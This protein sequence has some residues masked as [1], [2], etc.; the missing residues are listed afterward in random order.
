MGDSADD[1]ESLLGVVLLEL[2]PDWWLPQGYSL[3]PSGPPQVPIYVIDPLGQERRIYATAEFRPSQQRVSSIAEVMRRE[4][5]P[6][7]MGFSPET[8]HQLGMDRPD[9]L[10]ATNRT[11]MMPF[12]SAV[13]L[14]DLANYGIAATIVASTQ[15]MA[16]LGWI[17]E[18]S[19]GQ[20]RRDANLAML[21]AG[22]EA[23][24]KLNGPSP[25]RMAAANIAARVSLGASATTPMFVRY[26]RGVGPSIEKPFELVEALVAARK[27]AQL[28][29]KYLAILE[30][31]GQLE[32]QGFAPQ[33]PQ[34]GKPLPRLAPVVE[35]AKNLDE[36]RKQARKDK[37]Y[38]RVSHIEGRLFNKQRSM[39]YRYNEIFVQKPTRAKYPYWVLD[40]YEPRPGTTGLLAGPVSRKATQFYQIEEKTAFK[41]LAE[42]NRKYPPGRIF[43]NVPSNIKNGLSNTP[44]SGQRIL[45]VPRQD[46][47]IPQSILDEAK[48]LDITILETDTRR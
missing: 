20:L 7:K 31:E 9:L 30:K 46:A 38:I 43:A 15:G 3:D 21:V 42:L 36:A 23:G 16:Q 14:F 37:A 22:A 25:I 27:E 35:P 17:S 1:D 6:L 45:E 24:I 41:Y 29:P 39:L 19:A 34:G 40:S 12:E 13:A 33:P 47:P 32:S 44:I 10:G 4:L 18:T 2:P 26:V 28:D 8:K 48:R 11:I 5:G